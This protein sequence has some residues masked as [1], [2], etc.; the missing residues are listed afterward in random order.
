MTIFRKPEC[1]DARSRE[2]N[3]HHAEQDCAGCVDETMIEHSGY[4]AARQVT[5]FATPGHLKG[6]LW[7]TLPPTAIAIAETSPPRRH[8]P[9]LQEGCCAKPIMDDAAVLPA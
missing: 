1:E 8:L 4:G 6:L 3:W 7:P 9:A 2:H 5:A